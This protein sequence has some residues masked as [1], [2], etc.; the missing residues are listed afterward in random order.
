MKKN[1]VL[2]LGNANYAVAA[3]YRTGQTLFWKCVVLRPPVCFSWTLVYKL[4]ILWTKK[5]NDQQSLRHIYIYADYRR[6]RC[7]LKSVLWLAAALIYSTTQASPMNCHPSFSGGDVE[8]L[9]A[10][11][12]NLP[13]FSKWNHFAAGMSFSH[14]GAVESTCYA[15]KFHFTGISNFETQVRVGTAFKAGRK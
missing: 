14:G 12:I 10:A 9:I 8:A 6:H 5:M 15:V 7:R 2:Q 11:P 4:C 3:T 13:V 1:H